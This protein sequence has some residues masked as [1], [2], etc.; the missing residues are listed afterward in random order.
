MCEIHFLMPIQSKLESQDIEQIKRL[1]KRG[2]QKNQD[3]FGLF[4]EAHLLRRP[5]KYED[6]FNSLV[7]ER[8]KE[9]GFIVAHNRLAT[10]GN[11]KTRN[12]HPFDSRQLVWVHNGVIC[13][14]EAIAAEYQLGR[15]LVDSEV[16]GQ[17]IEKELANSDIVSA[18]KQVSEKL[19]GSYSVFLWHKPSRRL[20]YFRH[21]AP[22]Y[23]SL[24]EY[25]GRRIIVGSS[26]KSNLQGLYG[27][28]L[29]GFDV[30]KS[31]RLADKEP[32]AGTIYEVDKTQGLRALQTF[33]P[34]EFAGYSRY[35]EFSPEFFGDSIEVKQLGEGQYKLIA[36]ESVLKQ[37]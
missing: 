3:G 33:K 11:I 5:F 30:S 2:A 16:I 23:F 17:A 14:Y 6:K 4:D 32:E 27:Q 18:I 29:Y 37:L 26:V 35:A 1:L 13:N 9:S 12:T 34:M 28:P 15:V 21:A 24:H 22:F 20:F 19:K 36:D 8:F 7:T 25:Q 31:Q 10:H